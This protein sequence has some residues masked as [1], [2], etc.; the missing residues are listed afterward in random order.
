MGGGLKTFQTY[1]K[2]VYAQQYNFPFTTIICI[3]NDAA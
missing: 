1:G 2:T 3:M